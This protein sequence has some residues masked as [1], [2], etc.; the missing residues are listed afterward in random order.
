VFLQAQGKLARAEPLFWRA[1]EGHE[2]PL[3][4]QHPSTLSSVG[5]LAARCSRRRGSGKPAYIDK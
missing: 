5:K 1:L 4:A 2:Q 3:G